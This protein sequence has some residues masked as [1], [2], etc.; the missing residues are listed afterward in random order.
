MRKLNAEGLR[1]ELGG[2][3]DLEILVWRS[4]SVRWLRA[5]IHRV[6]GGKLWLRLLYALEERWPHWFGEKGQYPLVVI[7]KQ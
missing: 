3:M 4:V 5:V 7:R 2:E 1:R 6:L